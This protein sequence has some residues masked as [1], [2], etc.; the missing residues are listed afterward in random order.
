MSIHILEKMGCPLA[1]D[2]NDVTIS[3]RD[4]KAL[5]N[6]DLVI[7][8]AERREPQE[9]LLVDVGNDESNL[10]DV[11]GK[12]HFR[13]I[14]RIVSRSNPGKRATHDVVGDFVRER[15]SFFAPNSSRG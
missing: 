5:S 15:G 7:P 13:S 8:A 1:D 9:T 11:S 10:I 2:A 6:N 4:A 14:G 3:S 12:Q